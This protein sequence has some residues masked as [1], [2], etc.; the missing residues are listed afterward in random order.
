MS[1]RSP[2]V[3]FLESRQA[4][5]LALWTGLIGAAAGIY[6]SLVPASVPD[7]RYS[8]PLSATGHI[9]MQ[10]FF[11][12]HHVGLVVALAALWA[13]GAAGQNRTATVGH[14]LG[15]GGM[16]LLSVTE[17]L[18]ISA[19]ESPLEGSRA[20]QLG[21]A[22]GLSCTLVGVGLVLVGIAVMR[23]G[24]W[25]GWRR[26]VPLAIGAWVFVPLFPALAGPFVLARLAIVGWMLLFAALGWGL[27]GRET[28]PTRFA[29]SA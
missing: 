16:I 25:N 18:A 5:N 14:Y 21:V 27:P 29:R 22:Y 28:A 3:S 10:V 9:W 13:S 7:D 20:D 15:L 4:A 17:L 24:R 19:A 6:L 12:I 11:G 26:Y 1:E 8:Y 23:S 2:H